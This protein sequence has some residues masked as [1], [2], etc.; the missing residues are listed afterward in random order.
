MHLA[1]R[2]RA[3]AASI[4]AVAAAAALVSL[5]LFVPPIVGLANNGDYGRMMDYAGVRYRPGTTPEQM[6]FLNIQREFELVR[7][8]RSG[9]ATCR[10]RPGSRSPDGSSVRRFRGTGS[11]TSARSAPCT[12]RFCSRRCGC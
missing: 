7:P 1:P 6:Y 5:Q 12:R 3:R 8:V 9:R 2:L 4:A 11:S 10:R